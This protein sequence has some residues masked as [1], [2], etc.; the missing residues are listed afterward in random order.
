MAPEK[1][2][3]FRVALGMQGFEM[4]NNDAEII[5]ETFVAL[6]KK[7]GNLSLLETSIIKT[8]VQNK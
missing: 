1:I 6:S 7:G 2:N 8:K 4:S 3:Q 5:A